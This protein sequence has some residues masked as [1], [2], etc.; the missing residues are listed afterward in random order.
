MFSTVSHPVELRLLFETPLAAQLHAAW[1]SSA[2][3]L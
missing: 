2:E 1:W 3:K